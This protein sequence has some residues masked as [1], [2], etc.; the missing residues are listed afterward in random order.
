MTNF[1]VVNQKIAD[2][3]MAFLGSCEVE[4]GFGGESE[5]GEG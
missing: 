2:L 3:N 5:D 1:S 4:A